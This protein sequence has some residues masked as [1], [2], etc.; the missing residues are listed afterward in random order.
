MQNNV[1]SF[2]SSKYL[3]INLPY[4]ASKIVAKKI[5]S[6]L[7]FLEFFTVN[8]NKIA[9]SCVISCAKPNQI[10]LVFVSYKFQL[11]LVNFIP[12]MWIIFHDKRFIFTVN[13]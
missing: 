4:L 10:L 5:F 2:L 7:F 1:L 13:C 3:V 9:N 11:V 12:Y 8:T 6:R